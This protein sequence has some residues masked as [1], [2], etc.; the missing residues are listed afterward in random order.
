MLTL[1]KRSVYWQIPT[2]E[3]KYEHTFKISSFDNDRIHAQ[4]K[5]RLRRN[6]IRN[7]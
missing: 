3:Q 5:Y 4:W 2:R 7:H 1:L 6:Q